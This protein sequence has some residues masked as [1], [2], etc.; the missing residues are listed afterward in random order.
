MLGLSATL[1]R[2]TGW[3]SPVLCRGATGARC[4]SQA[5]TASPGGSAPG[6]PLLLSSGWAVEGDPARHTVWRLEAVTGQL[7]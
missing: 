2:R 3:G 7:T 4:A 5:A 1:H 6:R